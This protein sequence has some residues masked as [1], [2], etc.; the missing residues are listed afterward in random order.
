MIAPTG[1][2]NGNKLGTVSALIIYI[3]AVKHTKHKLAHNP[4]RPSIILKAFIMPTTQKIVNGIP[5]S[6]RSNSPG[7]NKFPKL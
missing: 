7:P 4:F 3:I 1:K 6:P 5:H 2:I